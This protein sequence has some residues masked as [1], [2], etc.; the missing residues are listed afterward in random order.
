M[1]EVFS[2]LWDWNREEV[3]DRVLNDLLNIYGH[4]VLVSDGEILKIS[5]W[6]RR[7]L[8]GA[9]QTLILGCDLSKP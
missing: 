5:E 8:T 9:M 2:N 1:I 3:W 4:G 6:N 7:F